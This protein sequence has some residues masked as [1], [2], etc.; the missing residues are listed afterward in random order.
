MGEGE[1]EGTEGGGAH[2]PPEGRVHVGVQASSAEM[3]V[4]PAGGDLRMT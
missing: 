4:S 3:R 1:R 2:G